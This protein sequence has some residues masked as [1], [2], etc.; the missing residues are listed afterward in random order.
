MRV[1]FVVG[2]DKT[3]PVLSA[4][5]SQV[6]D[7]LLPR[8]VMTVPNKSILLE[9]LRPLWSHGRGLP[10]VHQLILAALSLNPSS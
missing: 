8:R 6:A 1:S 5:F 7:F 9:Y 4:I 10:F 2:G 3:V